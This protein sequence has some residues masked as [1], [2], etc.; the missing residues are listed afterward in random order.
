MTSLGIAFALLGGVFL[1]ISAFGVVVLP[2]AVNR[3]HAATKAATLSIAVILV[4][5]ALAFPYPGWWIR[6]GLI[7]AFLLATLPVG[8]HLLVRAAV[9]ESKLLN[10]SRMIELD[11]AD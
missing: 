8:S 5:A 2:D 4:G 3:Q 10:R 11:K 7:L 1:V 6:L 9:R